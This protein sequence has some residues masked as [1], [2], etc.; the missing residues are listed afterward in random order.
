MVLSRNVLIIHTYC[1]HMTTY[2]VQDWNSTT[3]SQPHETLTPGGG[4]GDQTEYTHHLM[5]ITCTIL[6]FV[7]CCVQ[8]KLHALTTQSL[9]ATTPR[10]VSPTSQPKLEANPPAAHPAV[11]APPTL[12]LPL[13]HALYL[14]VCWLFQTSQ[15]FQS[16][17]QLSL[18]CLPTQASATV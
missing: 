2:H 9:P 13:C 4:G 15:L 5:N 14:S 8:V 6:F 12:C 18:V 17:H 3:R 16:S 11:C 10:Q 7:V 1:R